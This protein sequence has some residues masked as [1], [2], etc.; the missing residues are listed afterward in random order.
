V[1]VR[2]HMREEDHSSSGGADDHHSADHHHPLDPLDAGE[3]RRAV[4]I[5]RREQPVTPEARIVS[6]SLNE[7]AKTQIAF[8]EPISSPDPSQPA[9]SGHTE[10]RAATVPREAFVV[11]LEPRRHATY[12][13]V[14]S[15]TTDTVLSWRPVPGARAPVT[16][17]NG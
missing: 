2:H 6:V 14:V 8:A 17:A 9:P 1:A 15:L 4:E 5:L 16:N 7:P 3:I 11:L 12:E 13:A 10:P